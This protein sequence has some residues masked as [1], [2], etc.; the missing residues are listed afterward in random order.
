MIYPVYVYG[1]PV[2]RKVAEK[3]DENFEGLDLLIDSMFETMN[4][5]VGVGLAAPQIGKSIQLIVIDAFEMEVEDEPDLKNFRKVFINPVIIRE[6][7]NKWEF[8]EGCLSIPLIHEDVSRH[9]RIRIAYF[10]ENWNHHE[11]EYDGVKAR[12]IQHEYDHLQGVLFVDRINPL[13]RKLLKSR[14]HN[15]SRGKVDIDYKI[16]YPK[17]QL[18]KQL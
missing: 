10:D 7:G 2:L 6:W 16:I 15:I 17:K 4:A 1:M 14:L 13:K 5:S 11:E 12:I 8:S 18:Q 9:S 3:I